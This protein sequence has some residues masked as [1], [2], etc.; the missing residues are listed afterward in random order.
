MSVVVNAF[1]RHARWLRSHIVKEVLEIFPAFAYG[2]SPR[3]VISELVPI[4]VGGCASF[5]HAAPGSIFWR[6][7]FANCVSMDKIS[8]FRS[9]GS[10]TLR[11]ASTTF[12]VAVRK[13]NPNTCMQVSAVTKAKPMCL[14]PDA[15][16]CGP[17]SGQFPEL[18]TS[19]EKVVLMVPF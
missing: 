17:I 7:F 16:T 11:N 13:Y 14:F 4:N 18:I 3:N 9:L 15:K 1:N 6:L 10:H 5:D 2:N 19:Q 8:F 12:G